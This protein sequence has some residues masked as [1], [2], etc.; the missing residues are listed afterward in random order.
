[1]AMTFSV[2]VQLGSRM[3]SVSDVHQVMNT[4]TMMMYMSRLVDINTCA[5][6]NHNQCHMI[7]TT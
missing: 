2:F 1:M 4:N 6:L 7:Y 3:A 5:K